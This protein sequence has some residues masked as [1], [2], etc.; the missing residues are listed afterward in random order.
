MI[1]RVFFNPSVEVPQVQNTARMV[2]VEVCKGA[3]RCLR[4]L[5]V[6]LDGT[7]IP[8]RTGTTRRVNEK[9]D[10]GAIL[11]PGVLS[12][13]SHIFHVVVVFGSCG[14]FL[15]RFSVMVTMHGRYG[16]FW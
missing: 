15:S 13:D 2:A 14:R 6:F 12:D 3:N 8:S 5:V 4:K 16:N 1:Q 9:R 7:G 10:S 11:G